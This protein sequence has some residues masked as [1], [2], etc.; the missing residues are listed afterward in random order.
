MCNKGSQISEETHPE[1]N[2]NTSEDH[3]RGQKWLRKVCL[4]P[5]IEKTTN[6]YE[7]D[8]CSCGRKCEEDVDDGRQRFDQLVIAVAKLIERLCLLSKYS[9]D[10]VRRVVVTLELGSQWMGS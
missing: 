2:A 9:Q 6:A 7:A 4:K 10:E 8:I 3:R 5:G 1:Q